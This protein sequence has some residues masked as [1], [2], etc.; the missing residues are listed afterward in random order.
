MGPNRDDKPTWI[1]RILCLVGIHKWRLIDVQV[2]FG[3]G[4]KVERYQCVRC[5]YVTTRR[6]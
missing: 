1:E 4:G 3:P 2:A 6:R 5:G